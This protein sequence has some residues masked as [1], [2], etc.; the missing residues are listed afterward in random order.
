MSKAAIT[1]LRMATAKVTREDAEER[2]YC[3]WNAFVDFLANHDY[4]EL[5]EE[6]RPAYLVFWYESEV[7]NGCHLQYFL[8]RGVEHLQ[9]A[10]SALGI[11]GAHCQQQ[12][13]Q[14][15]G[16]LFLGRRREPIRSL[17]EYAATALQDEFGALDRQF[18]DCSLSLQEC[19][20]RYLELHQS[21]FVTIT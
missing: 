10:I 3:V 5:S 13:L 16:A 18:Y 17:K 14:E 19:L 20:E 11:L 4:D 7:Q 9:E 1:I 15:A 2:P 12:V 8:N 6:Q 21:V